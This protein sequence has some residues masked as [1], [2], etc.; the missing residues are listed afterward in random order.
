M[1]KL[2]TT[3]RDLEIVFSE[4]YYSGGMNAYLKDILEQ[5]IALRTELSKF[6]QLGETVA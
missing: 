4:L 3:I 2:K 6:Y 1:E 5:L